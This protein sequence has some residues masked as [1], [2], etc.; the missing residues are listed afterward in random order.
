MK[1][2]DRTLELGLTKQRSTDLHFYLYRRALHP[3][4]FHIFM[5]KH[6]VY[7][8]FQ[9]DVWVSGLSHLVTVQSKDTLVAELAIVENLHRKDLGPLEKATSFREYLDRYECTQDELAK[10]LNLDRST[11]AN[12]IRLLELPEPVQNTLRSGAI[13]VGHARAMLPLGDEREQTKRVV[14]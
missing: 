11:I 6:L 5:D 7:G 10:R 2:E 4:L 14:G 9:A 8:D 3:E 12:L 1:S 13:S